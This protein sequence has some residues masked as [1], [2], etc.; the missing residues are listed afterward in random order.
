MSRTLKGDKGYGKR[1]I[2][3]RFFRVNFTKRGPVLL[4]AFTVCVPSHYQ[5][6]VVLKYFV[7]AEFKAP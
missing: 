4:L 6:E 3:L 2:I 5:I 1:G 7:S